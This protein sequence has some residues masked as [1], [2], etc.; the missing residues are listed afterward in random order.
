MKAVKQ[1]SHLFWD[2]AQ[3]QFNHLFWDGG[4]IRFGNLAT[5]SCG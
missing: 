3:G 4:S 1:S 5:R 2:N